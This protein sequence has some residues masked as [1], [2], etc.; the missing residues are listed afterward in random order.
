MLKVVRNSVALGLLALVTEPLAH[1]SA[2]V[3][4]T[5]MSPQQIS[6][7]EYLAHA[8]DCVAC[9]TVPGGAAFAGGRGMGTPLGTVYTT[10]IT[11]DPATG[12]GQYS[13]QDF[14]S[15][16]RLGIARDGHYLYPSMPYP[17][18][19]KLTDAD[20][21]ALYAFFMRAVTPVR[22]AN[23]STTIRWPLSLRWPLAIWNALFLDKASYRSISGQD[24]QWNRGAYLVQGLGHCGACHTPRGWVFEEEA[25][26]Q[27]D[28]AYLSGAPLDNWSAVNLRGD[29]TSGLGR[30][31]ETEL[32]EYLKTGHNAGGTAFGSMIDAINYSTQYLSDDDNAAIAHYL[33]S[34]SPAHPDTHAN[35]SY[36]GAT[37]VALNASQFNAPGSLEY[38]QYC[39]G[40]HG[41]DGKGAAPYIPPLAGNPAVLDPDAVS[42]INITLNGSSPVVIHGT[43]DVYRMIPFRAALNDQHVAELLTFIRTSWGN[44]AAPATPKQ[45]AALRAKTDPVRYEELD[46]LRMR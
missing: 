24:A 11:P 21:A 38:V 7:G 35:W 34:L 30:W 28:P 14:D 37:E 1:L 3:P 19:A 36:N 17:S 4:A 31:T 8:A 13:L 39:A 10:N 15:A 42:L 18:Y 22:Q 23:R 29:E 9:H 20:V 44:D 33:K 45:V 32:T 43:P 40:C 25:L 2:A 26:T 12:I 41:R 6:R 27:A 46:L 16:L 5:E